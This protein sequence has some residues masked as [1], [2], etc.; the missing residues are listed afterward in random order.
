MDNL[1]DLFNGRGGTAN[2]PT[3]TMN[4]HTDYGVADFH[5]KHRFVGSFSY[6]L[7]IFKQNKYF[8]GWNLNTIISLQSGV[9]ITPYSSSSSYDLNKDGRFT[10]RVA[11]IG[12]GSP[13]DSVT[14]ATSPSDG[15]F[16]T[17]QW[18]RYSC[19]ASVNDGFWCNPPTPR[20]SIT[21]PGFKNVDFQIQKQFKIAEEVKL[22]L[23]GNFFNLFNHTNFGLPST[24]Q[25]SSSFGR[26]IDAHSPR[27]TQLAF[28]ID[29]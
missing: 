8:G 13:M 1:S 24:N 14:D 2:G 27:V 12:S 22:S 18:A 29:F 7:P 16:D 3:D 21:A 19:P 15:Y 17:T 5:M 11:Y 9:P 25:T 6:E 20:G 4:L 26:S 28:R 23:M 10:D